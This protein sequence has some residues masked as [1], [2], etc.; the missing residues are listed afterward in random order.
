MAISVKLGERKVWK[1]NVGV[2]STGTRDHT[3]L[4]NR[5]AADQHPI[6]SISGLEKALSQKAAAQDLKGHV[7][8]KQNPHGLTAEHIGARPSDWM[9]TAEQVGA[10]PDNWMPSA[11]EVGAR[12]NTWLPTPEQIGAAPALDWS[13]LK[14][15]VMGD[16]LTAQDNTFT[17]KRYYDFVQEKTGIQVIVDGVGATGYKAG[18][19]EGQSFLDRV[20]NIPEDVDIVTIFG[21]G[22]DLKS[23]DTTYAN[24][25]IYDT[26]AWILLNRC[27]LRVI[28]VPPTPWR[29]FDKRGEVWKAYCDRLQVCALA[30]DFR[31]LSDMY[32]CPPIN[33]KYDS[34]VEKFFTNDPNGVHPNEEGHKALAPYFYNALLQE[35]ALDN[36][37]GNPQ[38][39]GSGGSGGAV[40]I[41]T[42]LP[43]PHKLTFTGAVQAEYDG[44]EAVSVEIPEGG[45][46][47]TG[48]SVGQIIVVKAVDD[49]GKP[50]EWETADLPQGGEAE[51]KHLQTVE[52]TENTYSVSFNLSNIADVQEVYIVCNTK[53]NRTD[54]TTVAAFSQ[55]NV[56]VNNADALGGVGNFSAHEAFWRYVFAGVHISKKAG[57]I[58][59][60]ASIEGTDMAV[61]KPVYGTSCALK[62]DKINDVTVQANYVFVNGAVVNGFCVG[63][64]FECYYR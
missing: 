54:G 25:A 50:T 29:N 36:D 31:Y 8:N 49:N 14:W 30:C 41:P 18:E 20:K 45:I 46:E 57:Y 52:L 23:T 10:R 58:T 48:A 37:V 16:S 62:A 6:K 26:L 22:N 38:G 12:P 27:G 32:D 11:S 44:S 24:A 17:N 40:D 5:D 34:H 60:E 3:K 51:W 43:N 19:S 63:S 47:V 13:H 9:P 15:Y 33:G 2:A 35:L 56:R 39:G 21:S 4:E 1:V 55:A 28:V 59:V 53:Q 42:T 64:T 61:A 7:D